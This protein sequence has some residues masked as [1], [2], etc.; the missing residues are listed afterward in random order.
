M[1][2]NNTHGPHLASEKAKSFDDGVR[3]AIEG[4]LVRPPRIV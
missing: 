2:V 1:G 4:D 3:E